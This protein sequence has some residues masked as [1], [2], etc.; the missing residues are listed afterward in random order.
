MVFNDVEPDA[1]TSLLK[2]YN[3]H[4]LAVSSVYLHHSALHLDNLKHIS[5]VDDI[6]FFQVEPDEYTYSYFDFVRIPGYID[7]NL[8]TIREP[9][10]ESLQLYTNDLLLYLNP[11][12]S[13]R[14]RTSSKLNVQVG[15]QGLK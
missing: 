15:E 9:V 14:I 11:R 13:S 4:Y 5:S 10:I 3:I 2:L 1:F 7:G 12:K 8:K 6:Q